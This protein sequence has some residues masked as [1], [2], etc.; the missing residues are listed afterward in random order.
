MRNIL[1]L[2]LNGTDDWITY[3]RSGV[4]N[5]FTRNHAKVQDA[6]LLGGGNVST[7]PEVVSLLTY[8]SSFKDIHFKKRKNQRS[9][10]HT[11]Q[12]SIWLHYTHTQALDRVPVVCGG[13]CE[14][15][16]SL[17]KRDPGAALLPLLPLLTGSD[18]WDASRSASVCVTKHVCPWLKG[19]K[20]LS[21]MTSFHSDTQLRF[22]CV[23]VHSGDVAEHHPGPPCTSFYFLTP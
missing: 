13:K 23:Q 16:R 11:A 3:S 14:M 10:K 18:G 19:W 7:S 5:T 21:S 6:H 1:S 12:S 15:L 22:N 4:L 8:T 20:K 17:W 9:S 2:S